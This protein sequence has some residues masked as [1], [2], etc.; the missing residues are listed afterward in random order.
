[1]THQTN[2]TH[3]KLNDQDLLK[4]KY[5]ISILEDNIDNL[6][7]YRIL[8]TQELTPAFCVKYILNEEYASCVEET[9]ICD[10]DVLY[11]QPHIK[12]E[13]LIEERKKQNL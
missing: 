4:H 7:L 8:Y 9:Y 10:V 6:S 1:M 13:Q 11:Y 3:I 2:N 5:S 12:Q